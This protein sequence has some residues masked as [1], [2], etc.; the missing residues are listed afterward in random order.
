MLKMTKIWIP[1][2]A[3]TTVSVTGV[4]ATAQAMSEMPGHQTNSSPGLQ[5]I[6]Q[7]L[8]IKSGVIV[9]GITLIG[10]ELWWFLFSKKK[11]KPAS[12]EQPDN[13]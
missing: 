5:K 6:E 4:T 3:V 12:D 2:L 7:P 11:T 13:S 9:G 8:P 1:L 10:L